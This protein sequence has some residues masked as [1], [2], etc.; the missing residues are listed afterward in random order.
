MR[1]LPLP[2]SQLA[3]E[4]ARS[5]VAAQ[6]RH[7]SQSATCFGPPKRRPAPAARTMQP[8][9][10]NVVDAPFR[11]AQSA[12]RAAVAHGDDL[13]HDREGCLLGREGAEVE[14]DWRGDAL[15]RLLAH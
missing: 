13:T 1:G 14:P 2:N 6:L 11:L 12:A 7:P 10:A 4:L 9:S 3:H 8:N 15:E 5:G